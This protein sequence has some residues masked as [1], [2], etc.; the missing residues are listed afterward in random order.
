M[1]KAKDT[2]VISVSIHKGGSGKSSICGNLGYAL[3]SLGYKILLIDTDSQKNLTRSFGITEPCEKN[4]YTAFMEK[5]DIRNHIIKT[6]YNDIDIVI[7]D[8]GLASIEKKMHSMDYRELRM[9]EI[10]M[11]VVDDGTYDFILID[12]NSSLGMLNTSI[13]NATDEILIPV[14]PTAFGIEGLGVFMEHYKA[15]KEYNKY[16]NILGIV[17]NKVDRR[18]NLSTDALAVIETVF[19]D[20]ILKTQIFVDSNIENAQW[21][22]APLA[23]IY[24]NSRAVNNFESLAKEVVEIVNAR[25]AR[26]Y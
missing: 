23:A 14:E 15:I 6:D 8:V 1:D 17:L 4:F 25:K 22:N 21:R 18:K 5:D 12:T 10:L 20:K 13:L 26:S 19:G 24:K 9:S 7:G 2:K 16:L 3:A 11:N